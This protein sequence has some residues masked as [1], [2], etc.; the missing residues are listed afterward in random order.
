MTRIVVFDLDGTLI[1]SAPDLCTAL[2]GVL[3]VAGRREVSADETRRM[4][5]SGARALL[6]RAF[7]ATG[8]PLEGVPYLGVYRDF[9]ARYTT[10]CCEQTRPYPGA[11][12]LLEALHKAGHPLGLCTNK[13]MKHTVR[14]LKSLQMA[15]YFDALFGGDSLATK[16]PEPEMLWACIAALGGRVE[17]TVLVGDSGVDERAAK[18]AGCSFIGVRYGYGASDLSPD[19]YAVDAVDE[20]WRPLGLIRR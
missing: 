18:A 9:L 2:N 1:D 17:D 7:E 13:P 12:A 15:H 11:Y 6:D 20:L 10:A 4:T 14:I 8:G 16:K 3:G 19:A 5:G